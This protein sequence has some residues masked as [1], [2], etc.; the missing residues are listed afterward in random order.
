MRTRRD[1]LGALK[2]LRDEL[3]NQ[4][5]N[6]ESVRTITIQWDNHGVMRVQGKNLRSTL[7]SIGALE[8]AKNELYKE[9][10]EKG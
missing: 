8:M 9:A 4:L 6:E 7:E 5:E 10:G 3:M 1:A 2:E